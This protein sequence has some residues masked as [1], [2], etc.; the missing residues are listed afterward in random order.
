ME[1]RYATAADGPLLAELNY[2]LIRDE[3]HPNP[4]TVA[5]LQKRLRGWLATGY[6][7]VIFE[8]DSEVVAYAFYREDGAEVYL[9]Q[10]F[11]VRHRRRKGL[12]RQAMRLLFDQIWPK[13]KR[14][15]VEVL[16]KNKPALEFWKALGYEE[17][18]LAL[19]IPPN[20]PHPG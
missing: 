14:L 9:R 13:D 15:T 7:A 19:E 12:G 20:R 10:F 4:M 17:R 16:W 18:S 1:Y 5:E 11:V 2:Q 8:K 6:Q 3:G